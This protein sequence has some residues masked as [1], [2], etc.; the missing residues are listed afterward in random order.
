MEGDDGIVGAGVDG[1]DGGGE[2][3]GVG[4]VGVVDDVDFEAVYFVGLE[5]VFEVCCDDGALGVFVV[6]V[7][8]GSGVAGVAD[9]DGD[10]H[11]STSCELRFTIYEL[12]IGG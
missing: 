3:C 1:A 10:F 11:G 9:V 4:V 7:A 5:D 2:V 12:R 8:C 6:A